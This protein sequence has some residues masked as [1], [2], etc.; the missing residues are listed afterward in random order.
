MH[1]V[2]LA[3]SEPELGHFEFVASVLAY[4]VLNN[5]RRNASTMLHPAR[6]V[7]WSVGINVVLVLALTAVTTVAEPYLPVIFLN[8]IGFAPLL[9]VFSAVMLI[10]AAL[11]LALLWLRGRSILDLWLS[12]TICALLAELATYYSTR[13]FSL[14]VSTAPMMRSGA[15]CHR[16]CCSRAHRLMRR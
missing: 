3:F 8:Q 11:S 4:A 12:V 7:Y 14:V 6:L 10:T 5:T 13:M 2:R 15:R 16:L 9:H 1:S